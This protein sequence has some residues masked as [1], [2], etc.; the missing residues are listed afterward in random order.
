M[1]REAI[2]AALFTLVSSDPALQTVSRKLLHWSD[3][4]ASQ[5]PALFMAQKR[6]AVVQST[7]RPGR[8][9]LTVDL[10]VYVST[11]GNDYPGAVLNPILDL[12]S[13]KLDNPI[14]GVPQTLGG[15]VQWAR[16]EGAIETDEGTLGDDAVAI[17]PVHIL[18]V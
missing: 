7:G 10:Y 2:Y 4:P 16:I 1:N 11:K 17:I 6:E 13:S 18:T 14:P 8:W 12:I 3:V 5:R 9:L 15:L